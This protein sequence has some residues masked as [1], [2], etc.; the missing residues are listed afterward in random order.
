LN[1]EETMRKGFEILGALLLGCTVMLGQPTAASVQATGSA[2]MNVTPDQAQLSIGV[3]TQAVTA[4]A[5]GQANATLS[6]AVQYAL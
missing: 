3:I 2:T 5:A 6:N 4:D 1:L